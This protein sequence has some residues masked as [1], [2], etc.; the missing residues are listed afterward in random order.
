MVL[1]INTLVQMIPMELVELFY[2]FKMSLPSDE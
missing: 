1:N 2:S